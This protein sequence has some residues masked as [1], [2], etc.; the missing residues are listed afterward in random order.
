ML[1][2]LEQHGLIAQRA[3]GWFDA[4]ALA[5]TAMGALRAPTATASSQRPPA[6]RLPATPGSWCYQQFICSNGDHEYRC[7]NK[8][9]IQLKKGVSC[10]S[11]FVYGCAK[12]Q[13]ACHS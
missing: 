1:A 4:D 8:V 12:S 9:S 6:K 11:N 3:G 5:V 2:D 7:S 13:S 10:Y